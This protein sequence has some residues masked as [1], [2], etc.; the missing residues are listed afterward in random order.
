MGYTVSNFSLQTD[1]ATMKMQERIAELIHWLATIPGPIQAFIMAAIVAPLRIIYDG[2]ETRW[3]RITLEAL[4]CGCIS[5]GLYSGAEWLQLPQTIAVFIGSTVGFIGVI[6]FRE[7]AFKF[8][9]K[10]ID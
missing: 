10:R 9:G 3:E 5:L 2:S 4:L 6:K 1:T 8:I 7:F